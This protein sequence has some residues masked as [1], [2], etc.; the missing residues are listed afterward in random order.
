LTF[1]KSKRGTLV[2]QAKQPI[3]LGI[4]YP[5]NINLEST[6]IIVK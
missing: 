2:L 3:M 1:H 6:T 4:P 5:K